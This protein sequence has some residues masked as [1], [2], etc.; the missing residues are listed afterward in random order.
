MPT[1]DIVIP[2]YN[3]EKDLPRSIDILTRHLRGEGGE[4]LADRHRRQ[5]LH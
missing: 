1:V 2:V 5:W 4:S 3:E